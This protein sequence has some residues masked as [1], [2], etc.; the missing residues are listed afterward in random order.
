[1]PGTGRPTAYERMISASRELTVPS[2]STSPRAGFAL[3]GSESPTT[4]ESTMRASRLFAWP[5]PF[6]SPHSPR[7]RQNVPLTVRRS[8]RRLSNGVTEVAL[9]DISLNETLIDDGAVSVT[10]YRRAM[11]IWTT[12]VA[13][14]G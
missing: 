3:D 12:P 13:P 6:T 1:M 10:T 14:G 7:E 11:K 4:Y 2:P 5:S 8:G 9:A